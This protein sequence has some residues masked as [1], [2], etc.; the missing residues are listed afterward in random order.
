[1][2]P[3]NSIVTV[4]VEDDVS[5]SPRAHQEKT[6][7]AFVGRVQPR[8][9][10]NQLVI[11]I[12]PDEAQAREAA[13]AL[14]DPGSNIAIRGL[15]VIV[16]HADGT[17]SEEKWTSR[18]PF[19]APMGALIGALIGLPAGLFGSAIGFTAGGMFGFS[20]DLAKF[21]VEESFFNEVAAQLTPGKS[22]LVIE[23][24]K[25]ASARL[26]AYLRELGAA[27][28]HTD[29]KSEEKSSDAT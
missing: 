16:K 1:L 29:L 22:A 14:E 23:A 15:S 5:V 12:F 18:L 24:A 28:L 7:V 21:G 4:L 6:T 20:R 26:D 11:A 17:R 9:R 3:I 25:D 10:V 13:R 27:V 8:G 2:I 19:R